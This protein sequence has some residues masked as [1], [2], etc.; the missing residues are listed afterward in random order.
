MRR[1]FGPGSERSA[2]DAAIAALDLTTLEGRDTPQTVLALCARA[3]APGPGVPPVAAV[4]V[5]P[6]LVA[7]AVAALRGTG[8]AVASVATG[9]PAGLVPLDV[10]LGEIG[11]A[12]AAGATEIDVVIDRGAFLAGR[13]RDVRDE[14]AAMREACAGATCKVI[15]EA[16]ELGSY[17][18][19]GHAAALAL[20]G[21]ADVVKT[22]TGKIPVAST[23]PIAL[24]LAESVREHGRR[25]GRVAG[26]KLAGGI[27]T[28]S[29]ALGYLA[30]ISETLGP[31]STDPA[32]FR[33]GASS[34]LDDLL[35]RRAARAA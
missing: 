6:A 10:R 26:V 19:I 8:V 29:A 18:A 25:T 21:G 1:R 33:I 20:D 23:P 17:A 30:L 34:L 32:R 24:V 2:L 5:Y 15:L 12:V 11:A 16:G 27:R 7:A 28:A 3:A 31:G 14:V 9:F 35:A 22:A 13:F 4:C